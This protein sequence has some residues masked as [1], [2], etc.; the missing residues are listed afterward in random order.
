VIELLIVLV[1]LETPAVV[2]LLDCANRDPDQFSRG[3]EER[4]SWLAWLAVGVA[5]AWLLI[6]N[7]IVLAYYYAVI[8]RNTPH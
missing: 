7:G 4:R 6:G 8:R 5:T 1:V 2:A 3:A